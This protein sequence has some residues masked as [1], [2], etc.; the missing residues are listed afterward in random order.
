M[1]RASWALA[2]ALFLFAAVCPGLAD[3]DQV[4]WL[5]V[6]PGDFKR[7]E[8]IVGFELK[9]TAGAI[10]SVPNVPA[11]WYI[12]ISNDAIGVGEMRGNA[13]VGAAALDQSY[14][15]SFV[16]IERRELG[17]LKFRIELEV[18]LTADFV[19]ERHANF[20]MDKL[21]TSGALRR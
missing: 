1:Q 8:R 10:R 6:P 20:D 14:F 18:A 17:D 5:S 19:N 16:S 9:V 2:V 4:V 7:N 11:G 13:Q 12:S 21:V 3:D 15:N